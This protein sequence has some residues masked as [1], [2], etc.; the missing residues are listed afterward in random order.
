MDSKS[1]QQEYVF[2][3]F[4]ARFWEPVIKSYEKFPGVAQ[5]WS[6]MPNN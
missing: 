6:K 5:N 2:I 4:E 1:L 3:L